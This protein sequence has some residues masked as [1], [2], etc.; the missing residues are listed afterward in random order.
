MFNNI[1]IYST[2]YSTP[3]HPLR[4]HDF[5]VNSSQEGGEESSCFARLTYNSPFANIISVNGGFWR[6]EIKEVEW[7]QW[8]WWKE[9][10]G[11]ADGSEKSY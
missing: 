6:T 5:L 10:L 11:D 8:V 2:L 4:F 9:M 1:H 7:D 3:L